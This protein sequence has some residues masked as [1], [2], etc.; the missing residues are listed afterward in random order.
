MTLEGG[1]YQNKNKR[2]KIQTKFNRN[3]VIKDIPVVSFPD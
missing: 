2:V 3:I 1:I